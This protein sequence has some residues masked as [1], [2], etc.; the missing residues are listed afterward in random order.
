MLLGTRSREILDWHFKYALL[1]N[2]AWILCVADR[3]RL[4]AYSIF[5]SQ[6]TPKTGLKRIRLADF[7]TVEDNEALLLPMVSCA[8]ERC[9]RTGIHMLEIVGVS[10]EK[11]RVIAN[12]RPYRRK[13]SDLVAFYKANKL[14]LAERLKDPKR[15]DVSIFDG[16]SSL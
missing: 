6:N 1:Q 5:Y 12:L 9:R 8:L 10:P 16:D 11:A 13:L 7:Q 15:W 2:R 3:R 14:A 4:L